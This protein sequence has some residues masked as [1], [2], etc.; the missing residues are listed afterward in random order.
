MIDGYSGMR[1]LPHV[2]ETIKVDVASAAIGLDGK[3][4]VIARNV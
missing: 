3:A 4:G 1:R 2:R